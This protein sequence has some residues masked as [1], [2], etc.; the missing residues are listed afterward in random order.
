MALE[1]HKRLI[2]LANWGT[3]CNVE[4]HE[5]ALTR[6]CLIIK[7]INALKLATILPLTTSKPSLAAG[8]PFKIN[9]GEG[10][11]KKDSFVLIHQIRTISTRRILHGIGQLHKQT[12]QD[13]QQVLKN[14]LEIE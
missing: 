7:P 10:N 6:P 11:L 13:I 5:Q 8:K 4:G 2:V 12:F 14:F 9:E 3:V 1:L